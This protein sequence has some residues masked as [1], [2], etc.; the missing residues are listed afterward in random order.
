[1]KTITLTLAAALTFCA[2]AALADPAEGRWATQPD[3]NG[4][5]GIITMSM[6][7]DRLC[8]TLTESRNAS[9]ETFASA[10]AGRQIVWDME[11]RGNGEYRDGQIYAPDR[12]QTYRARMDLAGSQLT[13]AGC[14][15]FIC[16]DQIWTRAD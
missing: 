7:G 11:P 1:M 12:D 15:L 4:N 3:D 10:N 2:S 16:R 13:V 5:S 6:C 9:G 14:V 8:G